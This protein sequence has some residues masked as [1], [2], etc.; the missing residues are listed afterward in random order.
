MVANIECKVNKLAKKALDAENHLSSVEKELKRDIHKLMLEFQQFRDQL[1]QEQNKFELKS[2][3]HFS[4]IKN[5]IDIQR[6]QLKEKIE[7]IYW[8]M[9]KQVEKHET[10]YKQ[11]LQESRRIKEFD[12]I[13]EIESL[14][15][16]FRRMDLKIEQVHQLKR[17][18]EANVKDLQARL[19]EL[20]LM[21]QRTEK[22]SFVSKKD[23]GVELFGDLNLRT[24]NRILVSCSFDN[25]IKLWDLET[26]ECIRT[27]DDHTSLIE[28]INVLENGHLISSSDAKSLKVWNPADGVCL[29][30]IDMTESAYTIQVLSGNRVAC[31]SGYQI[32]IWNL[33]DDTCIQT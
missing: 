9:I 11:K 27:I 22:C 13:S 26:K 5:K 6:E 29:K 25:L 28:S 14:D 21:S 15:D 33:N 12:L 8:A 30:T 19:E 16:E 31:E 23:F 7:E 20:K 4:E 10:F 3:E 18:N 32:Q 17:E 1:N 2:H 24:L